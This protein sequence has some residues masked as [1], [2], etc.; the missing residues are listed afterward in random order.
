MK[1]VVVITPTIGQETLGQA[2]K[3]VKEQTYGNVKHL[4]V[5]DGPEFFIKTSQIVSSSPGPQVA[6][7]PTNTGANG[8]YG[9]RVYAAYPHLVN[10][11]YVAFLDEDNWFEPNH[12]ESL[13]NKIEENSL[14]WAYSLRSVYYQNSLLALDCCESIGRWPIW[15]TQDKDEKDYLV[16]TSSYCFKRSWLINHAQKWHSGWGGDRRFF[17]AIKDVSTYDTTGMHTLNYRLPDMQKAY[18]GDYNF[19]SKGNKA[20]EEFYGRLPWLKT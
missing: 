20:V 1:S 5:A 7:T 4:I 13:V 19:F 6:F 15:F 14:E 10:A 17:R 2:I 8:F 9:H 18:G 3:S 12:I 11:D 16:D